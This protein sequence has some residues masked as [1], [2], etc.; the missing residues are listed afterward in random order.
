MQRDV[1]APAEAQWADPRAM[2]SDTRSRLLSAIAVSHQWLNDLVA[3]RVERIDALAAREGRS[4][5]SVSM[6]LSLAFLAP[7]LVKAIVDHQMPRGIGLARLVELPSEWSRQGRILGFQPKAEIR[8]APSR[9]DASPALLRVAVGVRN[10]RA[11]QICSTVRLPQAG[12]EAVFCF[13]I[14]RRVCNS[15]SEKVFSIFSSDFLNVWAGEH[16]EK[17]LR[18]ADFELALPRAGIVSPTRPKRPA[19]GGRTEAG[20]ATVP[21]HRPRSGLAKEGVRQSGFAGP[22]DLYRKRAYQ[23]DPWLS[24]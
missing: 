20:T 6:L 21:V 3:G 7:M 1:I 10:L 9:Y 15:N 5:R 11:L 14:R 13:S 4:S 18:V 16:I 8:A 2:S 22:R 12:H 24:R 19:A 23:R 17:L